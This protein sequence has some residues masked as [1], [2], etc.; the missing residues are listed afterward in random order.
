MWALLQEARL[1]VLFHVGGEEKMHRDY[2]EN[3][4]PFV[5]DFHGGDENFTSLTFLDIPLSIWPSHLQGRHFQGLHAP[6]IDE[7]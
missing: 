7:V 1:P 4:L 6:V 3:G 2:L 5:K